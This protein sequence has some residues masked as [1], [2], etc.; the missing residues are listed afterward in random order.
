MTS[1]ASMAA[2]VLAKCASRT[3][4]R[5][6][7][8]ESSTAHEQPEM[9]PS[10]SSRDEWLRSTTPQHA[11]THASNSCAHDDVTPTVHFDAV[12][13]SLRRPSAS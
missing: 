1:I 11:R 12:S 10:R 2:R 8:D 5:A 6:C 13:S 4:K 7:G 9:S 3:N